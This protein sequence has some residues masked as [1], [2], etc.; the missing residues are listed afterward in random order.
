[1]GLISRGWGVGVDRGNKGEVVGGGIRK[2]ID[3]MG[4]RVGLFL[5]LR[6]GG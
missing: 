2:G 1:M 3:Y 4:W 5:A 6:L